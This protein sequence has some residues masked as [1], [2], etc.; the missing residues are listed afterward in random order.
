MYALQLLAAADEFTTTYDA[1]SGAAVG[2][3]MAVFLGL[4][5]F[6]WIIAM[7]LGIFTIWMFIDALIRKDEDYTRSEV[8]QRLCGRSLSS[9]WVSS[10][11]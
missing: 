8:V 5:I 4:G 3:I 2:G 7:V 6:F 1:S 10:R 11:Q 9:S